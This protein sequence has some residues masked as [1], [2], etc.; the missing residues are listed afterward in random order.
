[1]RILKTLALSVLIYF[2]QSSVSCAQSA[3]IILINGK[4]FTSDTGN[5]YVQALAI[6][7]NRIL[8]TGENAS[9]QKLAT[10]KTKTIDLQGRVVVPGFNQAHEHFGFP[11]T[12]SYNYTEFNPAGPDKA[13]VLDSI[14]RLVKTARPGQWI[15]G[16][17]GTTVLFDTSMR[18]ALDSLA[19]NTP[20]VLQI[21]WGHGIVLNAKALE[22]SGLTDAVKEPLGGWYIRTGSHK[23]NS[24]MENAQVPVWAAYSGFDEEGQIKALQAYA[25]IQLK[26]GFTSVQHMSSF[27]N[28]EESERFLTRA[29]LPQR[30]RIITWPRTTAAGRQLQ[31]L[32]EKPIQLTPLL[33]VSGIKYMI[34]GTPIEQNSMLKRPY[35]QGG[36]WFGR[37]DYPVDTIRQILREALNSD[38]QLMMHIVGDSS[39]AVVLSL[40]KQMGG[41]ELWRSKRVRIEH[42]PFNA[43]ATDSEMAA[44]SDLG[45]IVMHTPRYNDGCRLRSLLEKNIMV[46]MSPDG[47]ATNPFWDIM[48]VTSRQKKPDEN[49]TREQAVIAYTK[50]N[51]YAEFKEKEKGMLKK[52]MLADLAVLSQDIF[53][54]PTAQLPATTSVLTIV[55]GKIVYQ[56]PTGMSAKN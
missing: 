16:S 33:Y 54:V 45:I 36:N 32:N 37:L 23:I 28:L 51:A 26:G 41:R 19:P 40:M 50:T 25:Q 22:G 10:A 48:V 2:A 4:I 43:D 34:D 31:E 24:V 56:Q 27:Y 46:G 18:A 9:I 29:Q 53:N 7:G 42:N 55:D 30:I 47:G 17:I 3:D 49:I 39:A 1:M 35:A 12:P 5:L 38:R 11:V 21:W 20:V 15:T 52:G 6:K 13:A 8:A 14:A 44:L